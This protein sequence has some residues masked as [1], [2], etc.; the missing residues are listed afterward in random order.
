MNREIWIADSET[1]GFKYRRIPRPFIWGAYN[2]I[3]YHEFN[4]T[5]AFLEFITA[6]NCIVYAHNGGK[7]DW[8]FLINDL[9]PFQ[10]LQVINGR[11]AKFKIGAAEFRDS[12][13]ILPVP[14]AAYKKD[15]INYD[16]FEPEQREKPEVMQLI[17][18]YLRSDC[19]YLYQ[20]V[21]EFISKYGL[22]LTLA[23]AAMKKWQK[24]AEVKAP[25]TS[26]DFY[27]SVSPY[28]YGGRVECFK[29]GIIK[30]EFKV[31][32]LNSAYP[33]AMTFNHPY[34]SAYDVSNALPNSRA[35]T[36][37]AFITLSAISAGAFPYRD[38]DNS[39]FFPN[40][41]LPRIYKITGWEFLAAIETKSIRDWEIIEVVSFNDSV[42]FR[43]YV[44]YFYELKTNAE[45][46]SPDYIFAKLFLNSL[47]GKFG[48]NPEKYEEFMVVRPQYIEAADSEGYG[49]CTE[50]GQWALVSRPLSEFRQRYYNL[51]VA[52]SVTGFVRAKLLRALK[53]CDTPLYCDTDSIACV[54]SG[55]LPLHPTRLGDWDVEAECDYG[56]IAGKKLYAFRMLNGKWK[57]ASKGV[58]LT[59]DEII[60]VAKGEEAIY[61]PEAPTFSIK[62]GIH[63][64]GELSET[65]HNLDKMFQTRKVK[66]R[67]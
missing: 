15:E 7:F 58:K 40:D 60:K 27:H 31:I 64:F 10:P 1:E 55:A 34:G 52:A 63:I 32:D 37:R 28:Y 59:A 23:G 19:V 44:N 8:M 53:E 56:G 42:N 5:A 67:A 54:G 9:E 65:E 13:N 57:K 62:R 17:R 41:N 49:Y 2:G 45:K 30:R 24:I 26:A 12:Y 33:D 25:A 11:L 18:N 48:A 20:L 35:Y 51:A 6:R 39:L 21:I 46:N 4:S 16:L 50:V 43:D 3:E 61:M 66:L 14:L 47:Y 29:K 36:E 22:N 38:T